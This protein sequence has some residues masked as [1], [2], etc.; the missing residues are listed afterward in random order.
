[1][2]QL[3]GLPYVPNSAL[4]VV[5]M[6]MI[7]LQFELPTLSEMDSA[8]WDYE[9]TG[10]SAAGQFMRFYEPVLQKAGVIRLRK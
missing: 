7:F 4:E 1:L 2:W 8:V 9:L 10:L 6:E 3:G 5:A